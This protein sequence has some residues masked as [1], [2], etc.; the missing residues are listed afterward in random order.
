MDSAESPSVVSSRP[1]AIPI[2]FRAGFGAIVVSHFLCTFGFAVFSLLPKYLMTA[3]GLSQAQT[4]PISMGLPLGALL[5]S[6]L[7]ALAMRRVP[8]AAIVRTCALCFALAASAFVWAPDRALMPA[9]TVLLGGACMGVFNGGAGLTA[10]VAPEHNMARALGLHGAA[11]MLGHAL[12]PLV[13]EP[14]AAR[15]GWSAAFGLAATSA[16]FASMLP[17]PAGQTRSGPVEHARSFLRP[18]GSIL[19]VALLVGITHN[20]LWSAH[21]P[22]VL[23]R[24]GH[25]MRGYFLGMSVGAMCMRV[26]FGGLPDRVGHGRSALYALKL[27]AV[28]ALGMTWVTPETLPVFGLLHGI[29]HGVFYPALAALAAGRVALPARGEALTAMYAAFNVG[30]TAA[31]ASFARL[32]ESYGPASVFPCAAVIGV[33]AWAALGHSLRD[34]RA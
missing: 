22:L 28:A 26:L 32:G 11:G 2:A 10:E 24:G 23:A 6:P 4:G 9:L 14:L 21:Q 5:F 13:H 16:V 30:A 31:S 33:V 18:L 34:A 7:A 1:A 15:Y 3:R 12:G 17:L 19:I 20:A 25:E 29:A 8:K 27:Y